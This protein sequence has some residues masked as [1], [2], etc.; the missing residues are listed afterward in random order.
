MKPNNLIKGICSARF[1]MHF[2]A[3]TSFLILLYLLLQEG[4]RIYT[5]HGE[6]VEVPDVQGLSFAEATRKLH[7]CNLE[8][9]VVD[10]DYVK[11]KPAGCILDQTPIPGLQV[12]QSRTIYLTINASSS[13][14]RLLPD[15]AD[16]SSKRQAMVKLTSMGFLIGQ[17]EEVPGEKDWVYAIKYKGQKVY[18]GDRVPSDATLVLVVGSGMSVNSVDSTSTSLWDEEEENLSADKDKKKKSD[19]W[20]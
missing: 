20:F 11:S 7:D 16:N 3:V 13:P 5:R 14:T 12:K 8:A 2:F 4:L 9:L 6:A 18:A 10:S 19:D 1:W 15:L 17:V